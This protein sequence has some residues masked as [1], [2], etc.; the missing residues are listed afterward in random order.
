MKIIIILTDMNLITVNKFLLKYFFVCVKFNNSTNEFKNEN[1]NQ[2]LHKRV[3]AACNKRI[4]NENTKKRS[5]RN[6][7]IIYEQFL[8]IY[9]GMYAWIYSLVDN[10]LEYYPEVASQ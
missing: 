9:D 2:Y 1:V 4:D 7:A 6:C 5:K 10:L 3:D 8:S